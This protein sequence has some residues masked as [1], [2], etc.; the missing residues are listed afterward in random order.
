MEDVRQRK[1]PPARLAGRAPEARPW[2]FWLAEDADSTVRLSALSMLA[3]ATD[4][5][6][7][8]RVAE[9]AARDRDPRIVR[10]AERIGQLLDDAAAR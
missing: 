9:M 1:V 6:T 2:L 8:H 4:P 7:Q 5:A 10:L 3:T